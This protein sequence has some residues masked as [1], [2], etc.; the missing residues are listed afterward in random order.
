MGWSRGSALAGELW[1]EVRDFIPEEKRQVV[2]EKI[3]KAFQDYDCDTL[4]EAETLVRDAGLESEFY[5][6]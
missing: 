2:A 4:G 1:D 3:I 5:D 6:E